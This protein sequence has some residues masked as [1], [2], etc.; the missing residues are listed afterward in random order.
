ME[1]SSLKAK[2][3][4]E[5]SILTVCYFGSCTSAPALGTHFPSRDSYGYLCQSKH[6]PRTT[7]DAPDSE[8]LVR[9]AD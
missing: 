2:D 1:P 6:A 7:A 8:I 3:I 4:G 9:H 5:L